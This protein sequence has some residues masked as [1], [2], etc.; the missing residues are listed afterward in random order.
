M[1]TNT[2]FG[3]SEDFFPNPIDHLQKLNPFLIY[4]LMVK[5]D[6]IENI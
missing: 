2:V 5:R 1:Q 6:I 3:E 4:A